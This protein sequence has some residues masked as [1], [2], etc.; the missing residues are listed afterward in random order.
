MSI[1]SAFNTLLSAGSALGGWVSDRIYHMKAA[2][3]D[4]AKPY[5]I[6]NVINDERH[7]HIGGASGIAAALIQVTCVGTTAYE[8]TSVRDAIYG[9]IE[10]Y[11]S[12]GEICSV[13]WQSG[14]N[15]EPN[16]TSG[17]PVGTIIATSDYEVWHRVSIPGQ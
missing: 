12:T 15:R 14:S 2:A 10:N 1:E 7:R 6:W 13:G 3:P 16:P 8:A 5:V 4:V 9:D 17:E 11:T